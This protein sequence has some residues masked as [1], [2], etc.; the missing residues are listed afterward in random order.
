MPTLLKEIGQL[1]VHD[2]IDL[3]LAHGISLGLLVL[4]G[5]YIYFQVARY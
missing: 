1:K 3:S 4:Y 5:F 2:N